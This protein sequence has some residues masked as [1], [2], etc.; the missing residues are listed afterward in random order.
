[1]CEFCKVYDFSS[2]GIDMSHIRPML[3]FCTGR[4]TAPEEEQFTFCPRCGESLTNIK[5]ERKDK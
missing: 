5:T 2:V 1:M 4:N 3:Y